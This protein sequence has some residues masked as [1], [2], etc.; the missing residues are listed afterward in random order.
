MHPEYN[1]ESMN[2]VLLDLIQECVIA[3]DKNSAA[4]YNSNSNIKGISSSASSNFFI[5]KSGLLMHNFKTNELMDTFA[6]L[7]SH[8]T[9]FNKHFIQFF[10]NSKNDYINEFRTIVTSNVGELNKEHVMKNNNK[11]IMEK[12]ESIID[13]L[14]IHSV[15]NTGLHAKLEKLTSQ[16]KHLIENNA[17]II[18][19]INYKKEI[20]DEFCMNFEINMSNLSMTFQTILN[21][22]IQDKQ[23]EVEKIV[24]DINKY[25]E[26]IQQS[27][28]HCRDSENNINECDEH[29]STSSADSVSL[30]VS[31]SHNNKKHAVNVK[32]IDAQ[33]SRLMYE[34]NNMIQFMNIKTYIGKNSA[35]FELALTQMYPTASMCKDC[36]MTN[37]VGYLL[38]RE[39]KQVVYIENMYVYDRNLNN[40][41]IKAFIGKMTHNNANG[42]FISHH[43]GIMGKSNFY[44]EI[45]N[46]HVAVFI[47]HLEKNPERIKLAME[48]LDTMS[49]KLSEFQGN[50]IS[51]GGAGSTGGM[52]EKFYVPKEIMDDINREYQTY[53]VNKENLILYMKETHKKALGQLDDIKFPSLDKYLA[54]KYSPLKKQGYTCDLCHCFSVGTLKGLAA[55]KRGC[56]RKLGLSCNNSKVAAIAHSTSV[57]PEKQLHHKKVDEYEKQ[58]S[59]PPL[60]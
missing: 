22:Y 23:K 7:K 40:D 36:E 51:A 20:V 9:E 44:I 49:D 5:Q 14:K 29:S 26:T 59:Y 56:V 39:Q 4:M 16:F 27:L 50:G 37:R 28:Y 55:H 13:L 30:P 12:I 53:V 43:T 45:V 19:D 42:I 11:R 54:T 35:S 8:A 52:L 24:D 46:R 15:L 2:L 57:E 1:I 34:L 21:E 48:I 6:C 25:T 38:Y 60:Q 10:I 18:V 31:L 3:G 33:Y 41:E 47:H 17:T 32:N 58:T